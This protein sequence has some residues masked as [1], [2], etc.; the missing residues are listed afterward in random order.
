M[1]D[2]QGS[3]VPKGNFKPFIPA[4]KIMPELTPFSLVIG[5]VLALVFGGANAYLG[6]RVGQTISASIPAAVI[7]MGIIRGIFRRDSILENNVVQTI[8][9]A[10]EA[11]AGGAIF[12][13][14]A[15]FLWFNEWGRGNPSYLLISVLAMS[16]AI[17][18]I[19]FMVPLRRALIVKEH[20][21][22]PYPEGTACAR[23]LM[24]GESGGSKAKTTFIGVAVG[25]VY[26]FIS[27]GLALFPSKVQWEIP[28][29]KGTAFGMDAL[30][31]LLG[32]GYI[33]GPRI[34]SFM[35]GGGVL[36]WCCLLPVIY[37]F[38]GYAGE[39]IYPATMPISEMDYNDLWSNY[40]RYIGAGAVAFGGIYS[41]I[42]SL[43]TIVSS[44]RA[45]ISSFSHM[46]SD[47]NVLRTDSDLSIRFIL[48]G[49]LAVFILL[50]TPLTPVGIV[51]A[52]LV[53]ILGFFFTTVASRIVGMIGSSNNPVSGMTI[54]ALLIITLVFKL[55]GNT[56]RDSM[57]TV[58]C[59][60]AVIGIT[61]SIAGDTS[62]D[63]KTGY[64]VGGTPRK[65]QLAE[66][67]GA[68][69]SAFA[70]GGILMLLN[71]AWGFG[72]AEIPAVQATL[73]KLIVEGIMT[74]ELPWVLVLAGAGIGAML[75]FLRLPVLAVAIGL[76]LPFT[77]T[78]PIIAGGLVRQ[79]LNYRQKKAADK[80]AMEDKIEN[81]VLYASGLIAGEGL[82]G[83]LLAV[84]TVLGV[85]LSPFGG[86]SPLGQTVTCIAFLLLILSVLKFS[87]WSKDKKKAEHGDSN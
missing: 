56:G 13:L 81:G 26:K 23:V 65:M 31:A 44:F 16:G 49:V 74:G 29:Y 11:V 45:S 58:I 62:Q 18:G 68:I 83:I 82:V 78:T 71:S 59:I 53:I 28:N 15:L 19:L 75:A 61:T 76:Y 30:P 5:C 35:F 87:L 7:S 72:S 36:G 41:L 84:F 3:A 46:K 85:Q 67:F 86:S 6:L 79:I 60:A 73:M 25:M 69:L 47:G 50:C 51:G 10:G 17:L 33:I 1:S 38:G 32:V 14:P 48:I 70:V 27:D 4:D 22:L 52:L 24:A 80:A 39:V 20:E 57:V 43:P 12:T 66:L 42:T 9:S 40:L 2:N 8:G 34:S 21:T 63:L 64:L 54:A 77:L 37:F 55:A